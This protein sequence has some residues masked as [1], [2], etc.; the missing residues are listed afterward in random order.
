[1]ENGSKGWKKATESGRELMEIVTL[2]NGTIQR[3][4]AMEFILGRTETDTKVNGIIVWRV[5]T[6]LT[7]L[8]MEMCMLVN[9]WKENQ[10]ERDSTN[11][12]M[13]VFTKVSSRTEWSTEKGTGK[14]VGLMWSLIA[15]K[16]STSWTINMAMGSSNGLV[17]TAI[18]VITLTM[19]DMGMVKCT[20]LMEAYI[21]DNGR[22]EFNMAMVR[23]ISQTTHLRSA[24]SRTMFSRV[25]R[26]NTNRR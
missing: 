11:G 18:K 9:T 22:K 7:S 26:I 2:E 6:E 25:G 13:E 3:L 17:E 8:Q 1:M 20:G 24:S 23:C 21:K 16:E 19:N 15:M 4:M 5:G 10:K 14:R 12:L